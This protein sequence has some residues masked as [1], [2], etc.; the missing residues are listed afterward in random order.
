MKILV[1]NWSDSKNPDSGGAEVLTHEIAKRWVKKGHEVTQFCSAFSGGKSQE[2]IGGIRILRRGSPI[3][4]NPHI[5]V[6]VAAYMWYRQHGRGKFDVIVDEIHGIPFFTPLYAKEKKVVLICEVANELWDVTFPFPFN[7]IGKIAERLY[8]YLYKKVSFLTIS[9]STKEDLVQKGVSKNR[10][11]VL[12]MGLTIPRE[13]KHYQKEKIPT[14]L[15]VG[16][17][18]KTKGADELIGVFEHVRR[19]IPEAVLWVVGR[20][21]LGRGPS[22]VRQFGFVSEQKKFELMARAH[23]L[24]VP[25]VKEGWGLIVPE[26]GIVETPAVAHDVAGLRD[27]ISNNESGLLVEPNPKALAHGVVKL[28]QDKNLYRKLQKGAEYQAKQYS[29]DKTADE[30]LHTLETL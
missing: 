5:P 29:W 23:I 28:L 4:R 9:N 7:A 18:T 20:G 6:Q 2:I 13:T 30:A 10:I 3:I 1:F 27:V 17:L 8:F 24:V 14:I 22:G 15:F 16:R 19:S 26:A 21:D 11:K 25:S 12:P